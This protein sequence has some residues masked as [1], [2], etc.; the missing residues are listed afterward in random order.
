MLQ[1]SQTTEKDI[2]SWALDNLE[3]N[4]SQDNFLYSHSLRT[5]FMLSQM[6]ASQQTMAAGLLHHVPLNKIICL[7]SNLP[8]E[9]AIKQITNHCIYYVILYPNKEMIIF[10]RCQTA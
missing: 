8:Y 2:L 4:I 3:K 1:K 9:R 6:K 7:P 10:C 5:A